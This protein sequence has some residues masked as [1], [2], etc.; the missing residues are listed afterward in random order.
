MVEKE[1]GWN[2]VTCGFLPELLVTDFPF[3]KNNKKKVLVLWESKMSFGAK[4][5]RG[6]GGVGEIRNK[7]QK[8]IANK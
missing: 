2:S 6:R 1:V 8:A 7:K 5:V 4:E 3:F